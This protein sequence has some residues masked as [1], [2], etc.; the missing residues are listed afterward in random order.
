M[1]PSFLPCISKKMKAI[2]RPSS[3]SISIKLRKDA[4][5]KLLGMRQGSQSRSLLHELQV[6]QIELEM[7][8]ANLQEVQAA[9]QE[10]HDRYVELYEFSPIGYLTLSEDGLILEANLAAAELLGGER[11][12]LVGAC[13][14]DFVCGEDRQRWITHRAK[15]TGMD[16]K[17]TLDLE[18]ASTGGRPIFGHIDC[19]RRMTPAGKP[20]L[21]VALVDISERKQFED[22]LRKRQL[23]NKSIVDSVPIEIAVLDAQG[24]IREVNAAWQQFAV[25]NTHDPGAIADKIGIGVNYLDACRNATGEFSAGARESIE[26]I[27]AVL[28]GRQ[29]SFS[30]EYPCHDAGKRRWFSMDVSPMKQNG[31][32]AVITHADITARKQAEAELQVNEERLRLAKTVAGLGIFDHGIASGVDKWDERMREFW[33]FDPEEI[34]TFHDFLAGIHPAD[35]AATQA[36]LNQALDPRGSG[37]CEAEFRVLNRTDGRLLHLAGNAWVYFIDGAAVRVIGTVKEITAQKHLEKQMR[38]RRSEMELLVSQQVAAHTAAAIA[39]ELNQPLV[40]LSAYSEAASRMLSGKPINT[41]KLA[42][43]LDGAVKQAQRAGR[44][45]H[46]LIHFLSKGEVVTETIDLNGVILEG[47]SLAAESGYSEFQRVIELEKD[48]RPVLANRL[49]IQKVMVVLL[50]NSVDAM[51]EAGTKD[52][53]ISI[54][55]RT[56]SGSNMAH[57]T[58]HDTGPGVAPEV[59]HRIFEPF[60]TTKP[61][62]VGLGLAISRALVQAQG[63]Q[64]WVEVDT[65]PGATFHFTLPFAP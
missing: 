27:E 63:G 6:H 44:S 55:V 4:E 52:T 50:Q 54:S 45:L 26:G 64:L 46:E 37:R 65:G 16:E 42:R 40:A 9:L 12:R 1:A 5:R 31:Q 43:A 17:Q 18:I 49:Q 15:A 24:V 30:I 33:G 51:R 57:V 61:E 62:G 20:K 25:D 21:N 7:Q 22:E 53:V 35:R 38:D 23:F 39:H 34:L 29:A 19:L 10:S 13:F 48:L 3:R 58:V 47:I 28:A 60:F 56:F 14:D 2:R 59:V 36:R 41:E 8:N 11:G 32:G